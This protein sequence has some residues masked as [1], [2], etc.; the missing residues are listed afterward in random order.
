M[1]TN[2]KRNMNRVLVPCSPIPALFG[3]RER[4]AT[5]LPRR[6]ARPFS[7]GVPAP[8]EHLAEDHLQAV[9]AHFRAPVRFAVGYG[10][11]VFRQA[12][13]AKDAR[14]MLDFIF[15]VTHTQHWHSLNIKQNRQH[16]SGAA[17]LGSWAVSKLQDSFGAG[18]YYNTN[19]E[20]EGY[21]I[22]YGVVQLDR[23]VRDLENWDTMYL[24]GRFQKPLSVI[25]GDPRVELANASNRL[26]ALRLSLLLLPTEFTTTDLLVTI[27]GLSYRG[28]F[29]TYIGAENPNKVRNIVAGQ[30]ELLWT[31]YRPLLEQSGDFV[32]LRG[33]DSWVQAEDPKTRSRIVAG[34]PSTFRRNL[35]Q[36]YGDGAADP[37]ALAL[38]VASSPNLPELVRKALTKTIAYPALAQS[39]KGIATAGILRSAMYSLD[40][41]RKGRQ[42]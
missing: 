40:K 42:K 34:L 28:D 4:V 18:V 22:K 9:L 36:V 17:A 16:Y 7:A 19:V 33:G 26:A 8:A 35:Y 13:Y 27:V 5:S 20:V 2:M 38:G 24:A 11:G 10:S 12:S 37:A 41:L 31:I 6:A 1:P 25:R 21:R 29:R 15:G 3:G 39:V 30:Q 14:P 23:L 32:A